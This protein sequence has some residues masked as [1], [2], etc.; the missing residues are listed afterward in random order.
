MTTSGAA[1]GSVGQPIR[2]PRELLRTIGAHIVR[3]AVRQA[4]EAEEQGNDSKPGHQE[5]GS[6]GAVAG[7]RSSPGRERN[8]DRPADFMILSGKTFRI[9]WMSATASFG[10]RVGTVTRSR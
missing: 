7:S 2:L 5:G 1:T 9:T 4:G 3:S 8:S 6:D 10:D